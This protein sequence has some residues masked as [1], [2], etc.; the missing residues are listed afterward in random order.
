MNLP[1]GLTILEDVRLLQDEPTRNDILDIIMRHALVVPEQIDGLFTLD[2][3]EHLGLF[4]DIALQKVF[5]VV[6]DISHTRVVSWWAE[7]RA[8]M[9]GRE[10]TKN[11]G[12]IVI[13]NVKHGKRWTY[14]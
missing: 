9:G 10:T 14:R 1:H 7:R 5:L 3:L 8:V 2:L 12:P 6:C 11:D 13:V 4:L